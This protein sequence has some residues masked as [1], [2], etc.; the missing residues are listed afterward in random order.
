[1]RFSGCGAVP[2][3]RFADN[4]RLELWDGPVTLRW[5]TRTR[6]V[7]TAQVQ[8]Q[9]GGWPQQSTIAG[10]ALG[11]F[12]VASLV[13]A[14]AL[15]VA[16]AVISRR[17]AQTAAV[18]DAQMLTE[19]L[20]HSVISPN[21][22][23]ALLEGDPRAIRRLDQAVVGKVT[24]GSLVRVKLWTPQG[25]IVYSDEHRLIGASYPLAADELDVLR[26]G[27]VAAG[28][29][30]LSAAENRFEQ[31]MGH[32]LEV[33]LPVWT[34]GGRALLFETYSLSSSVTAHATAMWRQ[35]VPITLGA[36]LVLQLL[37]VPLA[38]STARRLDRSLAERERLQR[39]AVEA[40]DTERRRIARD[41]HQ[42]VVQGLAAASQSLVAARSWAAA[43]GDSGQAEA[44]AAGERSLWRGLRSLRTLLVRIYP[45]SLH[46]AG[47]VAALQ[48]LLE[49]MAG[50]GFGVRLDLP[51]AVAVGEPAAE[52]LYRVAR[53]QALG[54]LHHR[55]APAAH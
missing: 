32:L 3:Q 35:F 50:Q 24:S 5:P 36:L 26:L 51:N 7:R 55:P 20:A 15:G 17:A 2:G 21:L 47:L 43:R 44:L 10:R 40:A 14:V 18:D 13:V 8:P 6:G 27:N 49:P 37:Q 53:C 42:G 45:P 11:S 28:P 22:S 12:A 52:L 1:V 31:D 39:R 33:Y 25:R 16:G 23:D 38:W 9:S 29:S 4:H 54:R 34:P 30:E 19:V 41:L 48:D 46:S